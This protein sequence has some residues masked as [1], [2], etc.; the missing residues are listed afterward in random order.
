MKKIVLEK[1]MPINLWLQQIYEISIPVNT[2]QLSLI[3][4]KKKMIDEVNKMEKK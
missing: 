3:L 2:N 1:L 4:L